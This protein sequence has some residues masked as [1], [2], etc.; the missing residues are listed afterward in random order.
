MASPESQSTLLCGQRIDS[1]VGNSWKSLREG[2][3]FTNPC[4]FSSRIFEGMEEK[5]ATEF[6]KAADIKSRVV[7]AALETRAPD[8][9][10]LIQSAG[11]ATGEEPIMLVAKE[12]W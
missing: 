1:L 5:K 10:S 12:V 9:S 3:D 7:E 8:L 4:N 2:F 11:L 6:L